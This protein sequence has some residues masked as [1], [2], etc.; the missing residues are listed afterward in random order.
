MKQEQDRLQA[1]QQARLK[2]EAEAQLLADEI[3][4]KAE[5]EA[6]LRVEAEARFQEE[7]ARLQAEAEARLREEAEARFQEA[8]AQRQA[9]AEAQ[10]LA[11]EIRAKAEEDARLQEE[12]I[13]LQSSHQP[14]LREEPLDLED[15]APESAKSPWAESE[16]DEHAFDTDEHIFDT[17]D[18]GGDPES[19]VEDAAFASSQDQAPPLKGPDVVFAEKGITSA[20]DDAGIS[21]DLL[22]RLSSSEASERIAALSEVVQVGGEDAFRSISGAFDD[23]AVEVR[24]A[25]ARSLY[26]LSPDRA[27]TFTRVLR[28]GSTERRRKIGQALAASGLAAEAVGNLTG[29][30]RE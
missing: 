3:L 23:P 18:L 9:E 14:D 8:G 12:Q 26:D 21:S 19:P 20:E 1:E 6:R 27:A 10:L 28:E 22:N 13:D 5:E 25:A 30:S 11:G 7:G 24:S 15:I 29:E 16:L 17:L 2:V 4:K